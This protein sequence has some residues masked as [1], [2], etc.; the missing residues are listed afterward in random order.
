[1]RRIHL[2]IAL[3]GVA[4]I[5]GMWAVIVLIGL[6]HDGTRWPRA[7]TAIPP[8]PEIGFRGLPAQTLFDAWEGFVVLAAIVSFLLYKSYGMWRRT[9]K[10]DRLGVSLVAANL[11][12]AVAYLY[13]MVAGLF[14]WESNIWITRFVLRYPL[15]IILGWGIIQL[16]KVP[17]EPGGEDAVRDERPVPPP[18]EGLERRDIIRRY[19]FGRRIGDQR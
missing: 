4:L 1:M 16:S 18:Y 17:D 6:V 3:Q 11:A 7:S 14:A 8:N 5:V 9:Y 10:L 15:L 2:S 19:G 13:L 12:F